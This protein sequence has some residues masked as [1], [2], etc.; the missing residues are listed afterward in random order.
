MITIDN[1][2]AVGFIF[3]RAGEVT[4][5]SNGKE[6]VLTPGMLCVFSPIIAVKI[7]S[8]PAECRLERIAMPLPHVY[9]QQTNVLRV[10]SRL[11][12]DVSP[13]VM[14]SPEMQDFLLGR[15]REI[16]E[17]RSALQQLTD[18]HLL[19][20]RQQSIILLEQHLLVE[21]LTCLYQSRVGRVAIEPSMQETVVFRFIFSLANNYSRQ[22][23]VEFYAEQASMS[24]AY[25]TRVVKGV[26]G[27]TP[28]QVIHTI[29]TAAA[30]NLL[31]ETSL[32]IKEVARELGFPEQFTFRKYFKAHVGVSP[33][34][35]RKNCSDSGQNLV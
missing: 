19:N 3:C 14:L 30:R 20:L 12:I 29:T 16:E 10:L 5:M 1:I 2:A 4:V 24:P 8:Q 33:T 26:T 15:M 31:S 34:E 7:V 21:M 11:G 9:P 35:Y 18:E 13:F 22:R 28:M 25:F 32:S 17:R 6:L 27:R 23:T